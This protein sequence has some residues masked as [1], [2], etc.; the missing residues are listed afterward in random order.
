MFYILGGG[1]NINGY[2][3]LFSNSREQWRTT[4]GISSEAFGRR[5]GPGLFLVGAFDTFEKCTGRRGTLATV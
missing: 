4:G 2:D 5:R 1:I 3:R